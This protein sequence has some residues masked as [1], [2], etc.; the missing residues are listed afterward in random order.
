MTYPDFAL[1]KIKFI[2]CDDSLSRSHAF[3]IPTA[4]KYVLTVIK[5][6]KNKYHTIR[7]YVWFKNKMNLVS[8]FNIFECCFKICN[9]ALENDV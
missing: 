7:Y 2:P 1:A 8:K 5:T 3:S 4:R 9:F 6:N